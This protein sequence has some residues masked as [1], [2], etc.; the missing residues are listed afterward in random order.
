MFSATDTDN[1]FLS[2]RQGNNKLRPSKNH[3]CLEITYYCCGNTIPCLEIIYF[4]RNKVSFCRSKHRS[5]SRKTLSRREL[6]HSC[7]SKNYS[8][9]YVSYPLKPVSPSNR[10]PYEPTACIHNN[11]TTTAVIPAQGLHSRRRVRVSIFLLTLR[12]TSGG[13]PS[14]AAQCYTLLDFAFSKTIN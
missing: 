9:P 1:G 2:S 11:L 7:R 13:T 3:S 4:Y 5:C 6:I 12:L 10:M 14:G 8:R